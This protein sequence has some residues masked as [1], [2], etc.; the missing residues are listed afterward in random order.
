METI[1]LIPADRALML[2]HA[3]TEQALARIKYDAELT[4][5]EKGQQITR[6]LAEAN[7]RTLALHAEAR[8]ANDWGGRR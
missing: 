1:T 7:A 3:S 4:D 2:H 8:R 6:L 5:R